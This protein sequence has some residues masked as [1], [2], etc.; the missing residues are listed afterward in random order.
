MCVCVCV[1]QVGVPEL[2]DGRKIKI[3]RKLLQEMN[4]AQL[5]VLVNDLHSQIESENHLILLPV[6][7]KIVNS[8][9]GSF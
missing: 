8:A 2:G 1:W 6:S 5:Q 9:A 4:L 3:S 7:K